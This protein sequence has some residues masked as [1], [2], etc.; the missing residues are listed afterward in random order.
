MAAGRG[1]VCEAYPRGIPVEIMASLWDHRRPCD[2]DHGVQFMPAVSESQRRAMFAAAAGH[3][4]FGIPSKV[5]AE[6]ANSD[7]GGKLPARAKDM[8]QGKIQ[9]LI[10]YL[11]EFFTEEAREPEHQSRDDGTLAANSGLPA[12]ARWRRPAQDDNYDRDAAGRFAMSNSPGKGVRVGETASV[13][14]EHHQANVF[15]AE[16]G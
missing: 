11:R 13:P 14:T 6:F 1:F 8:E 2:G 9:K 10:D 7:P 3:S 4:N 15:H 12:G 16:D 5:G